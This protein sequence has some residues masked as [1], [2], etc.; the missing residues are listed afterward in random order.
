MVVLRLVWWPGLTPTMPCLPVSMLRHYWTYNSKTG[1]GA[2]ARSASLM[3]YQLYRQ[4]NLGVVYKRD[5]IES[6]IHLWKIEINRK[7]NHKH[8]HIKGR[9]KP[10]E[11]PRPFKIVFYTLVLILVPLRTGLLI[12]Q[13][14]YCWKVQTKMSVSRWRQFCIFYFAFV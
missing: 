2:K 11:Q 10:R 12:V 7:C 4:F 1:F 5:K 14:S 8:E 9:Q 3:F 6:S 13:Y